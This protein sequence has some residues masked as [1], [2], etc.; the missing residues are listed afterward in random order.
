MDFSQSSVQNYPEARILPRPERSAEMPYFGDEAHRQLV[1]SCVRA[2]SM[3]E[4]LIQ[5]PKVA[6]DLEGN[7]ALKD[8][9]FPV[10]ETVN[11]LRQQ[12][13]SMC[14]LLHSMSLPVVQSIAKNTVAYDDF[15]RKIECFK[16]P[17]AREVIP[18]V[19]VIALRIQGRHGQFLNIREMELLIEDM[20]SYVEGYR[21]YA[22]FNEDRVAHGRAFA[23]TNQSAQDKRAH[24]A[25]VGIDSWAG[26]N[27]TD[28]P[29]FIRD[30][31]GV[32]AIQSLIKT[33]ERMCD[34]TLDPDGRTHILQ[35][36]L[37]VGCSKHLSERLKVYNRNSLR[38]INKP[39]GLTLSILRKHGHTVELCIKNVLRVWKADQ[40][41]RAEQLVASIA[42]SL[43]HQHGFNA[44]ETGGTGS[45]TITSVDGLKVNTELVIS[46]TRMMFDNLRDSLAEVN[47]RERFRRDLVRLNG[48]ILDIRSYLDD[49]NKGMQQL[50]P[51]Y[52]WDE[53]AEKLADVIQKLK[54]NLEHKKEAL[55]FWQLMLQIERII[56]EEKDRS[57]LIDTESP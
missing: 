9:N 54:V 46:R 45:R 35:S 44:I 7:Q 6:D 33:F 42:G 24:R 26:G 20:T 8:N 21:A 17:D 48:Q 43:V 40:L 39:L 14:E 29:A 22:K 23:K 34:R 41:A 5:L 53:D 1:D 11:A 31:D 57:Q 36:P 10:V 49:C 2:T 51:G 16:L 32:P 50:N 47:L 15:M 25:L 56:V 13:W 19:Y 37:Y 3:Y 30:D 52:K 4:V 27:A 38:S 55:R 18:G 12:D 28:E